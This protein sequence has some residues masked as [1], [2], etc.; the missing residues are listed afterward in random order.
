MF[1][2]EPWAPGGMEAA[3]RHGLQ[4]PYWRAMTT[5]ISAS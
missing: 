1:M 3:A 4:R 5:R 2:S